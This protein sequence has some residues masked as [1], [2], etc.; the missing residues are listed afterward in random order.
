MMGMIQSCSYLPDDLQCLS[1]SLRFFHESL[2]THE[3]CV[4]PSDKFKCF[5]L[6]NCGMKVIAEFVSNH[7][8]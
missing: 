1:E 2:K 6:R 3:T 4:N 8:F 5:S 7:L